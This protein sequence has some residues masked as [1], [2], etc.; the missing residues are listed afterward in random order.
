MRTSKFSIKKFKKYKISKDSAIEIIRDFCVVFDVDIDSIE[1]KKKAAN[2]ENLLNALLEY[3]MR[4]FIEIKK[5]HSIVQHLQHP[6]GEVIE[7]NYKTITGE[8][9]L[10]M[11]GHDENDF[12]ARMY[13]VLGA[14]SGLGDYVIKKLKGVDLKVAEAL[15][16]AFL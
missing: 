11:D 5:D 6:P 12:Y 4:G 16:I 13:A 2:M 14:A 8:E 3:V 9:K 15:T 1:D 7:I 10:S